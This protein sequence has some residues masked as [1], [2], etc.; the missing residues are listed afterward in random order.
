MLNWLPRHR[1][2][3][4]AS[5]EVEKAMASKPQ[6]DLQAIMRMQKALE[7]EKVTDMTKETEKHLLDS[8]VEGST[9]QPWQMAAVETRRRNGVALLQNLAPEI[10]RLYPSAQDFVNDMLDKIDKY[11][12]EDLFVSEAQLEWLQKLDA[13]YV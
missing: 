7:Q 6:F 4:A 13:D 10:D 2:E 1:I 5:T 8:K 9:P 12:E 3:P 11:G